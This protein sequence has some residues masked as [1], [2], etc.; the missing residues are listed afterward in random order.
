MGA[1]K[2]LTPFRLDELDLELL[3]SELLEMD[4]Y[5]YISELEEMLF[6]EFGL[7][8]EGFSRLLGVLMHFVP[9]S[10]SPLTGVEYHA[11]MRNGMSYLKVPA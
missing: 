6:V 4:D 5:E 3:V 8:F 7:T 11:L 2:M 10:K 9:V 1:Q